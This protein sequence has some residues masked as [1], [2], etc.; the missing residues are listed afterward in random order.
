MYFTKEELHEATC[1]FTE[2]YKIGQGAYGAV[3][4][5]EDLRSIGTS[6]AVKVLNEVLCMCMI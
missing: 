5:A 6:A 4:I 3:Y 2:D 1:G